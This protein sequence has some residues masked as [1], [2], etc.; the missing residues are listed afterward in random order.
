[1]FLF[2]SPRI[3][4]HLYSHLDYIL[5]GCQKNHDE[6][7]YGFHCK[8]GLFRQ[9]NS[10][11]KYPLFFQNP[12]DAHFPC[13]LVYRVESSISPSSVI[14]VLTHLN[15][16]FPTSSISLFQTLCKMG[17]SFSQSFSIHQA[18]THQ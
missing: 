17:F 14:H 15:V 11:P 5:L 9:P 18:E 7:F 13:S 12:P 10:L 6:F 16:S 1:M 8:N 2:P 4:I 3:C